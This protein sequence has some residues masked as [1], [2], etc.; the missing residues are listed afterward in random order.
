MLISCRLVAMTDSKPL[1]RR[2][3]RCSP[4]ACALHQVSPSL[5]SSRLARYAS[6]DTASQRCLE[7][8]VRA[9]AKCLPGLHLTLA[10]FGLCKHQQTIYCAIYHRWSQQRGISAHT[11]GS[12]LARHMTFAK[13]ALPAHQSGSVPALQGVALRLSAKNISNESSI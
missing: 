11:F 5:P 3:L 8:R 1:G 6:W 10:I 9:S 4:R 12:E 2:N 13:L 7:A